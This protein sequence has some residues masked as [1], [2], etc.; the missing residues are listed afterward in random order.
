M[1][2]P[3]THASCAAALAAALVAGCASAPRNDAP[4]QAP[5][6]SAKTSPTA[7]STKVVAFTLSPENLNVD[8]VGMQ[9]GIFRA[10][11]NRD[12]AFDATVDGP[13]DALFVVSCDAKGAPV[14]GFRADTLIGSEEV[15]PEL[16]SVIDTGKMTLPIGVVENGKFVNSDSG[17]II[18]AGGTHRLRLYVPN[19]AGLRPGMH[20]RLYARSQGAIAP[21]PF[22]A[23]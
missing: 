16:G 11:G 17:A 2:S 18:L 19:S 13:F 5:T 23:Y 21:G 12:L 4:K 7:E 1:R 14:Y 6:S 9:D 22:F 20:V 8:K 3:L 10:D 15:P